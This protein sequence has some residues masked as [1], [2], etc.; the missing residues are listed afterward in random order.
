M[1][2]KRKKYNHQIINIA[3]LVDVVFLLLLFFLLSSHFIQESVIKVKLPRSETAEPRHKREKTIIITH[4]GRV[5]F[6]DKEV[7]VERVSEIIKQT[8]RP[9][10]KESI[11]IKPDRNVNVGLLVRIIDEV[12][13]AGIENFTIVTERR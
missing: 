6:M 13:M 8:L 4:D 5:Y 9:P 1:E 3:P 10:E 7:Q 11:R 12:R 2:F